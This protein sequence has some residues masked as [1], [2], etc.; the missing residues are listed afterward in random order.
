MLMIS[1]FAFSVNAIGIPADKVNELF[2]AIR[3]G[4]DA[5]VETII[6]NDKKL[7]D[8]PDAQGNTPLIVAANL[9]KPGIVKTLIK[10]GANVNAVSPTTLT[11][12]HYA[13]RRGDIESVVVLAK[14]GAK[15]TAKTRTGTQPHHYAVVAGNKKILKFLAKQGVDILAPGDGNRTML[16]WAAM[17]GNIEM[18]KMF[19]KKG[20]EIKAE[21]IDGDGMLHW[22]ASGDHVE[23]LKF[24]I[25]ERKFDI[26]TKNKKGAYPIQ[27]G[28]E[29]GK[30]ESTKYLLENGIGITEKNHNGATW[31]HSAAGTGNQELVEMLINK[32]LD[33]NA[34]DKDGSTP[35]LH[36][37]WSNNAELIKYMIKKGAKVNPKECI[38]T[39]CNLPNGSPLHNAAWRSPQ[40]LKVLLDEGANVST[41]NLHGQTAF[42]NAAQSGNL[43]CAEMLL[44]AGSKVNTVN[45][46]GETPLQTAIL[47]GNNDIVKLLLNNKA[48][49]NNKNK[50]GQTAMHMA[51][52][53]GNYK[54]VAKLAKH[55][56]K[57]NVKDT[58]GNSPLY[59]A[60]YHRNKKT[61]KTLM[62]NGA[63]KE[64]FKVDDT[65]SKELKDGEASVW[66]L[67]HSGWA[68]K[69][70]NNLLIFDYWQQA[71]SADIA[72][73]QNGYINPEQIKDLKVT[74]FASH[75]H[76]DHYDKS[77]FDW[78]NTVKDINYVLGFE[79]DVN[80]DYS[81]IEP[82]TQKTLD[83]V[84]ITP[85][86]STD[87][88][89]GF[90]V[91]VDGVT[92]YHP[93]DHANFDRENPVEHHREIDYLAKCCD[94]VDIAF[95]PI[96][97]CRFQDKVALKQGVYYATKKLKPEVAFLMHGSHSEKDFKD[98]QKEAQTKQKETPFYYTLSKGARFLYSGNKVSMK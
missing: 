23:M 53:Q 72:G 88:G 56:A 64:D 91:E 15:L 29:F 97:G 94:H 10:N 39:A 95:F 69:T 83:G 44:K 58:E 45:V 22:A 98:F 70:K 61:A 59:Y 14:A 18:F 65:F 90:L 36:A 48:D 80:V 86:T 13:A 24:L 9:A 77:I 8:A 54:A 34:T 55:K 89:E 26:R 1:S 52:I 17:G 47:R 31:L 92:I 67:N 5:K 84:K 87:S 73:I 49:L 63:K 96:T 11:A 60:I 33:I 66:Y 28:I 2:T 57:V 40:I 38:S 27:T 62:T 4:E 82:Q 43:Q 37:A 74:V 68:V 71:P 50:Q 6:T 81:Y 78:N 16:M 75:T 93:G 42:H 35:I 19:E 25:N 51:A 30:V 7:V 3:N 41:E 79:D 20:L 12:V 46:D 21:D 32:G 85:I 76:G